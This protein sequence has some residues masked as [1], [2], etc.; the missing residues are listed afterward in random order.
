MQKRL[1]TISLKARNT[2][3]TRILIHNT[4]VRM[5]VSYLLNLQT[6]MQQML[7]MHICH[8]FLYSD[9]LKHPIISWLTFGWSLGNYF[10]WQVWQGWPHL[11]DPRRKEKTYNGG[12]KKH[13]TSE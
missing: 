3:N 8:N 1:V 10:D 5:V 9:Y 13:N 6:L 2:A 11:V 7:L 12:H 4:A